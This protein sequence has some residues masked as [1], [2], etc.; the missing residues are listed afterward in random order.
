L[1]AREE[2]ARSFRGWLS[3][4]SPSSP[5]SAAD[6]TR[7]HRPPLLPPKVGAIVAAW[8][9]HVAGGLD[10]NTLVLFLSDHGDALGD[11]FLWRKARTPRAMNGH[12]LRMSARYHDE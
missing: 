6:D 8:E 10:E 11:H 3:F 2:R 7:A 12:V 5:S 9:R 1:G 4:A